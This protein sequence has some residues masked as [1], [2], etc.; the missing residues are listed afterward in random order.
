MP[1]T[2]DRD[3]FCE[4]LRKGMIARWLRNGFRLLDEPL[5]TRECL[6]VAMKY[7]EELGYEQFR[8][9]YL[10]PAFQSLE[11][12]IAREDNGEFY[13]VEAYFDGDVLCLTTSRGDVPNKKE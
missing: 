10:E 2:I 7:D 8:F 13:R 6:Y 1:E 12:A 3:A 11:K 5:A 4:T 9:L